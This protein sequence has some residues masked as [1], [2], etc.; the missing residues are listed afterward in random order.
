LH[1]SSHSRIL[2]CF[3][4]LRHHDCHRHHH[5]AQVL[6][7]CK[8]ICDHSCCHLMSPSSSFWGVL[9]KHYLVFKNLF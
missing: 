8:Q 1:L 6:S 7:I 3:C 5:P 4:I 9:K 2:I